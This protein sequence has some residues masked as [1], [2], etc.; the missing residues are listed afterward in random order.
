MVER[1]MRESKQNAMATPVLTRNNRDSMAPAT[2]ANGLRTVT[3]AEH[4]VKSR[5]PAPKITVSLVV[6][7]A[8]QLRRGGHG[9]PNKSGQTMA[10][11]SQ[12]NVQPF[13]RLANSPR[14]KPKKIQNENR[15]RST[16][17][18]CQIA[19]IWA[20]RGVAERLEQSQVVAMMPQSVAFC[21]STPRSDSSVRFLTIRP[22][23]PLAW[24][25]RLCLPNSL[26]L[27]GHFFGIIR[28]GSTELL[29]RGSY[30]PFFC[31]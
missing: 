4:M 27:Q 14:H 3:R 18:C 21:R 20:P 15:W 31:P 24:P 26:V 9:D 8:S 22:K 30:R 5:V 25:S 29:V 11:T 23:K 10:I 16:P 1:K 7:G 12:T 17:L 2:A 13:P 19:R 6:Q 28:K